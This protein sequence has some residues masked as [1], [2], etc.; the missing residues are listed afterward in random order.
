MAK[1]VFNSE[2]D[3]AELRRNGLKIYKRYNNY[4]TK[5]ACRVNLSRAGD[6]ADNGLNGNPVQADNM[7]DDRFKCPYC[8]EYLKNLDADL[9]HFIIGFKCTNRKCKKDLGIHEILKE[10]ESMMK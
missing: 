3:V 5:S 4:F 10:Y 1:I 6:G 9:L 8:G 7:A 2:C